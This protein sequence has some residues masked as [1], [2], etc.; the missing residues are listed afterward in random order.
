MAL[1]KD[2]KQIQEMF[3]RIAPG[4]DRL[5]HIL[6]LRKDFKWRAFAAEKI[7]H[8]APKNPP[9]I[10]DAC[11]GTADLAVTVARHNP[12]YAI[13][14]IDYSERM[15]RIARRKIERL[16]VRGRIFLVRADLTRLPLKNSAC[17]A[18]TVAFGIR[19]LEEPRKGISEMRRITARNGVTAILEFTNPKNRLMNRLYYIYLTKIL[20][21]LG[22][23]LSGSKAYSYLSNSILAFST[24][25]ELV[26]MLSKSGYGRTRIFDLDFDIVKLIVGFKM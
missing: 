15:L 16:D 14:G 17:A 6:S 7:K 19:N 5:N 8:L 12:S 4:Y 20:P 11:T 1:K 9:F 24:E 22:N 3:S 21:V 2:P 18:S 25:Q 13:I 26:N 10:L 23:F